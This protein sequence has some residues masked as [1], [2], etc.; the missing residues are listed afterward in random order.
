MGPLSHH[1]HGDHR[2]IRLDAFEPD[3]ESVRRAPGAWY[4]LASGTHQVGVQPG[5]YTSDGKR[6]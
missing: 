2:C 5:R 3:L 4:F 6:E 1:A